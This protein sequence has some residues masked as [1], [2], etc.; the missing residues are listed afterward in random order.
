V[1]FGCRFFGNF[2]KRLIRDKLF[3]STERRHT[4]TQLG[5]QGNGDKVR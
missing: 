3:A 5:G 1:C 4:G 2:K